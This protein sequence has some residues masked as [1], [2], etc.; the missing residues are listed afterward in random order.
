MNTSLQCATTK[1]FYLCS[2]SFKDI[3]VSEDTIV[4]KMNAVTMVTSQ[5]TVPCDSLTNLYSHVQL[6]FSSKYGNAQHACYSALCSESY[7][8]KHPQFSS[9]RGTL[10]LLWLHQ[11]LT[12]LRNTH[13]PSD[14]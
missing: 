7:A 4:S 9:V 3:R 2:S 1:C 5:L 12:S 6:Y 8:A 14:D 13:H 11:C 10:L